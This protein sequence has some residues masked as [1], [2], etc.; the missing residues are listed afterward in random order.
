M[1]L[2]GLLH[3]VKLAARRQPF[4]GGHVVTVRLYCKHHAR[5]NRLTVQMDGA[6]STDTLERASLMGSRKAEYVP[7][8]I[9]QQQSDRHFTGDELTVYT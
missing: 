2:K 1:F 6:R 5:L 3:C 8:E 7:H 9:D 4:D